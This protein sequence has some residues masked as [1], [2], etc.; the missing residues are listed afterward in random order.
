M[1]DRWAGEQSEA[2]RENTKVHG[3][4]PGVSIAEP[5]IA[6][7]EALKSSDKETRELYVAMQAD[8]LKNDQIL[9]DR[10]WLLESMQL[11]V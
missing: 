10:I 7:F 11:L 8:H 4:S 6:F 5:S 2:Q 1:G 3:A 9:L